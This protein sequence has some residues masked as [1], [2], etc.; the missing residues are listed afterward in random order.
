MGYK[1]ACDRCGGRC[2]PSPALLAQFS[3]QFFRTSQLAGDL[4]EAGYNEGDTVT[5]CEEC[6]YTL[7]IIDG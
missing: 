4:S 5:L 1:A 7:L 2:D 6:T 3:P